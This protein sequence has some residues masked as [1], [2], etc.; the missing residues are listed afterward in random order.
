MGETQLNRAD[1]FKREQYLHK[2]D[3]CKVVGHYNSEMRSKIEASIEVVHDRA[4]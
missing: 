1:D 3:T 2:N 4:K